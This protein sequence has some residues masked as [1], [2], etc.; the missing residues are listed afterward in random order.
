MTSAARNAAFRVALVIVTSIAGFFLLEHAA[1]RLEADAT[2]WVLHAAG[3][4]NLFVLGPSIQVFPA[5]QEPF[6]AVVTPS[7][8][9]LTSLL[10]IACL[11][12]L[13]PRHYGRRR[14]VA[15]LAAMATIAA[16]NLLRI[17]SSIAVGLA[18]G[19]SSLVLFHDWVGS[20]L[21]FAY[22]LGGYILMLYLL[23][24]RSDARRVAHG[25]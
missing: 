6:R 7:C 2:A 1:R 10:A 4:G 18:A 23:L 9:S 21:T 22:T 15:A 14:Y 5:G 16:G 8:S 24:P 3:A 17:T 19:P 20:V 25:V 13:V 12:G 11:A